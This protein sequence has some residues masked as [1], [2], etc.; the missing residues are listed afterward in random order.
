MFK[1][2]KKATDKHK[3]DF[4]SK[5]KKIETITYLLA[6]FTFKNSKTQHVSKFNQINY[7]PEKKDLLFV[8][9]K[10]NNSLIDF[11]DLINDIEYINLFC[12][13]IN[14][15]SWDK[16]KSLKINHLG[17]SKRVLEKNPLLFEEISKNQ[18]LIF[19]KNHS[20]FL[21]IKSGE[22]HYIISG[23]GNPSINARI[24]HYIVL[25]DKTLFK[26]IE[27]CLKG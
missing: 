15:K 18:K 25:N 23:S 26:K 2:T 20:K 6:G 7:L 22:N 24:E 21:M 13:R 5:E 9:T 3:K 4:F 16:I 10:N 12:S 11:C 27:S 17:I 8:I 1:Q 14:K 19:E